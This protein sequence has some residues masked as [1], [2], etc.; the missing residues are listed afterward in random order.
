V[1][2]WALICNPTAGTFRPRLLEA[3]Q[4]TLHGQGVETRLLATERPGHA[5]ELAREVSGVARVAVYGG[6]GTLREAAVG[7]LGR[8]LPL[9]FLPGGTANVMAHELG[10]PQHPVLAALA[11]LR[12]RPHPV[13]PGRVNGRPFLLMAGIGFDGESVRTVNGR[14]KD[15]VGKGA[16]VWSALRTLLRP[17]PPL[18]MELEG[19]ALQGA[20]L[21]VARAA[22]YGGPFV[23]HPQAGLL[24]ERLGLVMVRRG[25]LLP[26]LLLN[27][28]LG[29][30]RR[31]RGVA[32]RWLR[33]GRLECEQ[34][35]PLQVDGDYV[36]S[37]TAFSLDVCGESVQLCFPA[38]RE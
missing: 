6:D 5:T 38:E 34:P 2:T 27:L 19:E 14:L 36:G 16:Y 1:E 24:Q 15:W 13:R 37:E 17:L 21:V 26:F 25:S 22:H 4:R 32:L 35:V 28:G 8:A 23:V 20:W 7:L 18:R 3:V 29:W 10:L 31:S 30:H 9:V 12:G 11:G 33:E